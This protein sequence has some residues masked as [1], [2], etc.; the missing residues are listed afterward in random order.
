MRKVMNDALY[1]N[2]FDALPMILAPGNTALG[3]ELTQY[4]AVPTEATLDPLLWWARRQATYP[5]LSQM[6]HNYLSIPGMQ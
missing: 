6:A 1:D 2:I 5:C 4:L 3:N